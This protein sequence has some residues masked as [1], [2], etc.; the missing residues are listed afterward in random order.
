MND[1]VQWKGLN[2]TTKNMLSTAK[3]EPGAKNPNE[4]CGIN[5]E[6]EMEVEL[7]QCN[8]RVASNLKRS[9]QVVQVMNSRLQL[10]DAHKTTQVERT[11]QFLQASLC[12]LLPNNFDLLL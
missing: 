9:L 5:R 4:T 7:L 2:R 8:K 10:R 11:Q 6:K 3:D 1:E 12:L